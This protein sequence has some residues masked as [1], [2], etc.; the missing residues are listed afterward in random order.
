MNYALLKDLLNSFHE[1]RSPLQACINDFIIYART[2]FRA[3]FTT[4]RGGGVGGAGGG[5]GADVESTLLNIVSISS[6]FSGGCAATRKSFKDF[7]VVAS[8][9]IRF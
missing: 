7:R 2:R 4:L 6:F 8:W 3:G 9:S 5:A 1:L